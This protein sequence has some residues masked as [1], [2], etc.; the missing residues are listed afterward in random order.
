MTQAEARSFAE[1][2]EA[3]QQDVGRKRATCFRLGSKC[4]ELQGQIKE[5]QEI[6]SNEQKLE[7]IFSTTAQ[8]SVKNKNKLLRKFCL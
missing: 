6:R 7:K 2:R 4:R 3:D 1:K 8:K 5:Q